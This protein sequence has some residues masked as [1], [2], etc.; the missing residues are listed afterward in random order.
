[1]YNLRQ[2]VNNN[3]QH[4]KNHHQESVGKSKHWILDEI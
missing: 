1:M 3:N 4:N 2:P